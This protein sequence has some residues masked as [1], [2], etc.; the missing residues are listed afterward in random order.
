MFLQGIRSRNTPLPLLSRI[1]SR[2]PSKRVDYGTDG[3]DAWTA[4]SLRRPGQ[5]AISAE[6][7]DHPRPRLR[8]SA[9]F[10]HQLRHPE[11]IR[12]AGGG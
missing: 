11:A 1:R 5:V 9:P 12:V 3:C 2:A 8:R 7:M 10:G 4:V 6:F